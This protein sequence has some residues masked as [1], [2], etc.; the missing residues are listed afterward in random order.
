[1]DRKEIQTIKEL[2]VFI[3]DEILIIEFNRPE[4]HN[5]LSLEMVRALGSLFEEVNRRKDQLKGVDLRG[6]LLRGK[7]L[8][9]CAGGDLKWLQSAIHFDFKQNRREAN[10]LFQLFYRAYNLSLPLIGDLHGSVMGGGLCL[11]SLCDIAAAEEKSKFGFSEVKRGL[12]PAVISS[13]ILQKMHL[14]SARELMLTGRVFDVQKAYDSHLIQFFGSKNE[15]QHYLDDVFK[16]LY[17]N[18]LEAMQEVKKLFRLV[19]GKS[20]YEVESFVCDQ[21][22]ER[23][24]TEEAQEGLKSFLEKRSPSW[25]QKNKLKKTRD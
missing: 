22:A 2:R 19:V 24:L 9:F 11:A 10:D 5:A 15:V 3:Q 8:S 17:E 18:G 7:G 4:K 16:H 1:M 6:V 13:F 21:I 12:I 14:G 25:V 23:R 20:P